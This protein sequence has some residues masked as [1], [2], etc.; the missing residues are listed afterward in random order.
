MCF[1]YHQ[2]CIRPKQVTALFDYSYDE[3]VLIW[4]SRNMRT[5]L[6]DTHIGGGVWRLKWSPH[7]GYKLLAAGMHNGFHILDC[8]NITEGNYFYLCG[9]RC[10]LI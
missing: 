9:F 4:D 1:L 10:R 5:P 7:D 6:S 8:A 2:Y 3:H